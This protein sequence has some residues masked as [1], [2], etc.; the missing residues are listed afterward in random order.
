MLLIV[1]VM[2]GGYSQTRVREN[3]DT[4]LNFV[5]GNQNIHVTLTGEEKERVR[6]ILD[7]N[8]YDPVFYGIPSCGFDPDVSFQMGI[9]VFAIACDGVTASRIW[10]L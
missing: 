9:R 2:V 6:G 5:Y 7:G 8:S 1:V 3:G 4:T 10:E